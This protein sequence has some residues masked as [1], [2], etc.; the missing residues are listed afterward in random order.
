M[1]T[2]PGGGDSA[3]GPRLVDEALG[4][5]AEGSLLAFSGDDS[6]GDRAPAGDARGP[7]TLRA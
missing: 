1:I 3:A 2:P 6:A 7:G 4:L 5:L